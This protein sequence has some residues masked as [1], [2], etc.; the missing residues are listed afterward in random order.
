MRDDSWKYRATEKHD[1]VTKNAQDLRKIM[2]Q[3]LNECE[4]EKE[5]FKKVMELVSHDFTIKSIC[6]GNLPCR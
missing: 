1:N 5:V 3:F 2:N 4:D 6:G